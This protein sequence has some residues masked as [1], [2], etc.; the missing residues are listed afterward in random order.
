MGMHVSMWTNVACSS[1]GSSFL[2]RNW[3]LTK[4]QRDSDFSLQIIKWFNDSW[5]PFSPLSLHRLVQMS[6]RKPGEWCGP[7]SVC[8]AIL[9]LATELYIVRKLWILQEVHT[10]L[11][12]SQS[13]QTNDSLSFE[14]TAV[15]LLI[16]M[17]FGKG[18]RI[19]PRYIP[20][21][22]RLFSDPAFLILGTV[23]FLKQ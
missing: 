14:P 23:L 21:V 17:M 8:S 3:R 4:N 10:A 16:P 9:R 19:N 2:G 6:D 12:R 18:T 11:Y 20:V 22:L 5:S 7:A 15:L 1:S 13:G